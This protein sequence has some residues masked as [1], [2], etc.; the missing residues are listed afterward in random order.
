MARYTRNI[1]I[2]KSFTE[3][4]PNEIEIMPG[5]KLRIITAEGFPK[6]ENITLTITAQSPEIPGI[7]PGH[8]NCRYGECD[9]CHVVSCPVYL[10]YETL[11]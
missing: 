9:D 11:S 1:D 6:G 2:A 4:F 7:I 8:P 5:L 10:G 3:P